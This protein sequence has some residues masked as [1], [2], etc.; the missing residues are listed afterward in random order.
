MFQNLLTSRA[1]MFVLGA[2]AGGVAGQSP[3][4]REGV[5]TLL[6]Q[7]IKGGIVLGREAQAMA[8]KAREDWDDL[9]AEAKAELDGC[10]ADATE[11]HD[12]KDHAREAGG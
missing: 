9:V 2:I 5:R 1:A 11:G 4:V 3:K 7:A 6:R 10:D 8:E 12:C